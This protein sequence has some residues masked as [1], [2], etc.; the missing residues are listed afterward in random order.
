MWSASVAIDVDA[1]QS[2]D[3]DIK[4]NGRG[5]NLSGECVVK[6]SMREKRRNLFDYFVVVIRRS[7]RRHQRTTPSLN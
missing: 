3:A 7:R 2:A 6:Y 5:L 4:E 1:M